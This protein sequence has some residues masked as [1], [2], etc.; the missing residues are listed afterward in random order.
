MAGPGTD[1]TVRLRLESPARTPGRNSYTD[2]F[3]DDHLNPRLSN[4]LPHEGL[5]PSDQWASSA[6]GGTSAGHSRQILIESGRLSDVTVNPQEFIA[7]AQNA[8]RQALDE[9]LI[10]GI[11]Y[12]K[13]AGDEYEMILFENKEIEGYLDRMVEVDN[14]IANL[15]EYDSN[16]ERQCAEAIDKRDDVKVFLKLLSWFF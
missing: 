15:V 11:K 8:I 6:R 3:A 2:L 1:G 16:V 13:A 4:G 7:H 9:L 12:E 10:Q 5:V 14:S